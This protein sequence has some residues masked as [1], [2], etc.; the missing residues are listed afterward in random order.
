MDGNWNQMTSESFYEEHISSTVTEGLFIFL[1]VL[2]LLISFIEVT[3]NG[4]NLYVVILFVLFVF[5]LFYSVNY[6]KLVIRFTP[7]SLELHFGLFHRVIPWECVE[8]CHRDDVSIWRVGG[9]GIH[10]TRMRGQWRIMFNFLEY[11]RIV[12]LVNKGR[13][14]EVVFTTKDPDEVLRLINQKI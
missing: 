5:F 14:S 10:S 9:A 3:Y 4:L 12:L 7:H 11:L 2:F 1:T 6:R 8:K 13:F